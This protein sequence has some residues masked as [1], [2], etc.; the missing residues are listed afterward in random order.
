VL[1]HLNR[2]DRGSDFAW[3]A[4]RTREAQDQAMASVTCDWDSFS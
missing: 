4:A 2:D 1:L 3:V